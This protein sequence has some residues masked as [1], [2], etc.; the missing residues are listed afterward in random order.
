MLGH[1]RYGIELMGCRLWS[2]LELVSQFTLDGD[3]LVH[4]VLAKRKLA[5]LLTKQWHSS[6]RCLNR[7]RVWLGKAGARTLHSVPFAPFR[8]L[9]VAYHV[10]FAFLFLCACFFF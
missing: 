4:Q 3:G 5:I 6:A 2:T 1:G 10:S 9:F 8:V 7:R